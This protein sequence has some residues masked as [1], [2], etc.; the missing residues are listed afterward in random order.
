MIREI[1][2]LIIKAFIREAELP[3]PTKFI[4]DD[5]MN[6]TIRGIVESFNNDVVG[7]EIA[8]Q[9]YGSDFFQGETSEFKHSLCVALNTKFA[10]FYNPYWK[11]LAEE[12][13]PATP[14]GV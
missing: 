14:S 10:G 8:S 13:V 1:K 3:Q 6:T 7:F 5:D 12:F 11:K 2:R 9:L 4:S